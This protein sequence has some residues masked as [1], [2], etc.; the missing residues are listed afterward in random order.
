MF[1]RLR[2]F[3]DR[4]GEEHSAMAVI[5]RVFGPFLSISGAVVLPFLPPPIQGIGRFGGFQF[6]VLS[7]S[8]GNIEDLA[9]AT[10]TM[11][12][13]GN[14][15]PGLTGLF[16][17][18]TANDPQLTVSVDREALQGLGL[19][20]GQVASTLQ[21]LMGSV[22]VNDFDFNNRSYRVYVQAEAGF[23]SRPQDIGRYY[24]RTPDGQMVRLDGIVRVEENTAPQVIT[25]Y[26]LFR[27]TEING[28]AAPGFSSGQAIGTM[29]E[30]A[31][32]TLPQGLSF[33]W[34]GL[35]LEEIQS[36][37]QAVL[38]F[39]LGLLLVY[40][41][42]AGQYESVVLPFIILLSVPL[43]VFGALGAQWLRGLI[44]D[45]Y[46]QIGLVMLI[47]LSAKNGI[48][49][50]EFAEQLRRRGLSIPEAAVE[51]ARI[52]L[53]PILMT[54]FAFVLGVLPLVFAHGAGRA[55]RH[56]V[57]TSVAGG[58]L[59]STLLNLAIIPVLY[60]IVR[61]VGRSRVEATTG[62]AGE[63]SGPRPPRDNGHE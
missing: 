33:A 9:R 32:R 43:A 54:S 20:F 30:L 11:V 58:M 49:V 25:H 7:E 19:Q 44:N 36:G 14:R 17:S 18:F 55:A 12:A 52:R 27:S 21:T 2:P 41:T 23:R 1:V 4:P 15:T 22:Y 48:L 38:I 47:G 34:S 24:I 61:S 3:A 45:V 51:A 26:N 56:S 39:G 46:A 42:L 63:G 60:V 28:R 50:V 8:G 16:S 59:L 5:Q 57:G 10:D 13:Q 53:R 31:G 37:G 62:A 35:S 29:E 40:L 6:E